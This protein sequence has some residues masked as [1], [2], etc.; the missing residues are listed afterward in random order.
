MG[1]FTRFIY[2]PFLNLL[3]A[4]YTGLD[5]VTGGNADMGIAV[6]IFTIILRIFLLPL[7]IASSRS[8]SE[9][10]EI[11]EK[12]KEINR[13]YKDDPVRKKTEIKNPLK[14]NRRILISEG[15][16]LSVQVAIALMLY[17]LFARGLLGADLG[18]IY[19][20][21]PTVTEP[22]NLVFAGKYDLTRPNLFLNLI[23]SLVI[24]TVESLSMFTSPFPV[25]RKE[26]I[27]LQVFLPMVSFIIFA[28]LPAGKKLFIITTLCFSIVLILVRR[29]MRIYRKF[30]GKLAIAMP[31]GHTSPEAMPTER[32][33]ASAPAQGESG[34]DG[35]KEKRE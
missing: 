34:D 9:R 31:A 2:Q 19:G 26:I 32:R 23:Q 16:N 35:K 10:R 24:F 18:L 21:M 8:E 5:F 27:R 13:A 11:E 29:G 22:F 28:Y 4:V 7:S 3:V 6:I 25:T 1:L 12:V 33:Q 30:S 14:G 15:I 20:F 17:R